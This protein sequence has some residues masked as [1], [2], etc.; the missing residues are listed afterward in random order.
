VGQLIANAGFNE[1]FR[2]H[3]L[4]WQVVVYAK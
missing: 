3:S 4:A 2:R 1:Q